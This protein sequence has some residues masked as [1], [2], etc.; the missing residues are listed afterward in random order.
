[1]AGDGL[2]VRQTAEAEEVWRRCV[3]KRPVSASTM[4][5]LEWG[6]PQRQARGVPVWVLIWDNASW[7]VSRAVR[8]W[9]RAHHQQVKRQGQGVRIL[10]CDL[11]VTSPWLNPIE[12]H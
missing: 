10:V 6:C 1:L 2:L 7:H 9:I 4:Q 8:T 12:P 11:P 5:F 3:A